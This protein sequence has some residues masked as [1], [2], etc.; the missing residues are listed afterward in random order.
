MVT[1]RER[2]DT[3]PVRSARPAKSWWPL[4]LG[5]VVVVGALSVALALLLPG[6]P[7]GVLG[8]STLRGS[9]V[10][11]SQDRALPPFTAVELA[12]ASNV[13]VQVGDRQRVAVRGDDNLLGHVRT[14]VRSGTLVIATTGSFS[15]RA[16]MRVYVAVPELVRVSLSGSG[17][18]IVDG[19]KSS[20]FT[21]TLPGSGTMLVDGHTQHLDASLPGSGEMTMHGLV[22]QA[23]EVQ[24]SGSGEVQVYATRSLDAAVSGSGSVIYAG[25]PRHVTRTVTGSGAVLPE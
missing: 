16:P 25:N 5:V 23:V 1:L 13:S 15:T 12:G 6:R 3:H 24:L 8:G 22:A 7:G 2:Q 11:A 18:V 10:A 20:S 14:T 21:A 19:V 17:N 9:G 4:A